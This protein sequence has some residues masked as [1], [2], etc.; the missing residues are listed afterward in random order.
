MPGT[1]DRVKTFTDSVIRRISTLILNRFGKAF[2]RG[3]EIME[4]ALRRLE[5]LA[6]ML[7]EA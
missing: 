7:K 2:A 1:S 3:V 4:E 6:A 5:K